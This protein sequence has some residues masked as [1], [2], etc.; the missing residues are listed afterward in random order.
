MSCS[1]ITTYNLNQPGLTTDQVDLF[2]RQ[3]YVVANGLLDPAV[4]I[5][6]V[7]AEYDKVLDSLAQ[8]LH[9][10]G[11][12]SSTHD[13]LTFSKRL[14]EIY[15]KT[16]KTHAQYFDCTL[17]GGEVTEET[18]FWVG[19]A[20][21]NM[22]R[23]QR[24]LDAVESIIGPE[25]FSNPVQHVRIKPPEQFAPRDSQGRFLNG[26]VQTPPHQDHGVVHPQAYQSEIIT[27]WFPL[28]DATIE[29][30]CML[31]WPRS[32]QKGLLEHCPRVSGLQIPSHLLPDEPPLP[33]PMKRGDVL[34][35][36]KLTIHGSLANRSS[37]V[38]FS[39]DLRYNPIG[40]PTGRDFLPGFVA[41][42]RQ[43]PE[44][45]LR[46]PIEWAH[47]WQDCRRRVAQEGFGQ[48]NRWNADSP[49]CA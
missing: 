2:H 25:I 35:L 48:F 19:P 10:R 17:H 14:I 43:H 11:Q 28:W 23:N 33:L 16:G 38:R 46:D 15:K 37:D 13:N 20:V 40:Q 12:I 44:S 18:K 4:D 8:D 22:L 5:D 47:L 36:N 29:N 9:A 24:L 3:G 7:L 30:G 32:S 49:A 41:R 26:L 31:V 1:S 34:F 21:F 39:L 42:S 6:P 27:V 45:E